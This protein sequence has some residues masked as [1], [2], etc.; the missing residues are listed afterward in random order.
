MRRALLLSAAVVAGCAGA[1]RLSRA[2]LVGTTWR[3]VCPAPEIATAYARLDADGEVVLLRDQDRSRWDA[4]AIAEGRRLLAR[5]LAI[6]RVGPYQLQAAIAGAHA[7]AP[8]FD[9]TDWRTI[10]RLYAV[11]ARL[12]PSPV[13]ALNEAVAA[14]LS[15]GPESGLALLSP[16]AEELDGYHYFHLARADMLAT[17]GERDA[18]RAAFDRALE[19]CGSE[20]ERRAIR[21]VAAEKLA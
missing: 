13:V 6:R 2:D 16:I 3:E 14:A 15:E 12:E 1:A 10:R 20:A 17:T 8:T 5:A 21:R 9:D 7:S 19:L 18:A 11:L 4:E